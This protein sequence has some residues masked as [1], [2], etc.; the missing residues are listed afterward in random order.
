VGNSSFRSKSGRISPFFVCR[1]T[2][3]SEPVRPVKGNRTLIYPRLRNQQP[4]QNL[5][6][7]NRRP[8]SSLAAAV[9]SGVGQVL[10]KA[11]PPIW[12]STLYVRS[13]PPV[14][15]GKSAHGPRP[16]LAKPAT[17]PSPSP[18]DFGSCWADQGRK[19]A[20]CPS[21]ALLTGADLDGWPRAWKFIVVVQF[22]LLAA[23]GM[24]PLSTAGSL[25]MAHTP[26]RGPRG[27]VAPPRSLSLP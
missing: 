3:I 11:C 8:V 20:P 5:R 27:K 7:K 14:P 23:R 16:P 18:G 4:R 15:V 26:G 24:Q 21:N 10:G 19:A 6:E 22:E 13:V 25:S 2:L 12:A 1:G 9:D 17:P